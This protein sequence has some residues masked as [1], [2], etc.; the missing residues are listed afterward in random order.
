MC[1]VQQ[2]CSGGRSFP[3]SI[4]DQIA[5]ILQTALG[6]SLDDIGR[7]TGVIKRQRKFSGV[8]LLKTI[9]LT[10]LKSPNAKPDQ[11]VTTATQL[12]VLVTPQAIEDRFSPRLVALLRA[13]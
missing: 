13:L 12:G 7:Q 8:T 11:F 1:C 5:R 2:P 4:I 3:V 9:I 6:G 10:L